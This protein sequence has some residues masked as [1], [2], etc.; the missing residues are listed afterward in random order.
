MTTPLF[1]RNGIASVL[2]I[3]SLIL[4]FICL[5]PSRCV[6]AALPAQNTSASDLSVQPFDIDDQGLYFLPDRLIQ[7]GSPG[8][9]VRYLLKYDQKRN[10]LVIEFPFGQL[11]KG[12]PSGYRV[13]EHSIDTIELSQHN[14]SLVDVARVTI[15]LTPG[16]KVPSE[17]TLTPLSN[18]RLLLPNLLHVTQSSAGHSSG[19]ITGTQTPAYTNSPI[20]PTPPPLQGGT[21]VSTTPALPTPPASSGASGEFKLGD[22][23]PIDVLEVEDQYF[24][25]RPRAG[26]GALKVKNQFYLESPHRFVLDI[27]PA[28]ISSKLFGAEANEEGN[29]PTFGITEW[30]GWGVR[31]SQN[32]P[33]TVRVVIETKESRNF[34]V[35]QGKDNAFK[36]SL[37]IEPREAGGGFWDRLRNN[38]KVK[39]PLSQLYISAEQTNAPTKFRL[40]SEQP[41]Q[42]KV[43]TENAYRFTVDLPNV[44]SPKEPLA[45]DV[46]RF[47]YLKSVT[48]VQAAEGSRLIVESKLPLRELRSTPYTSDNALELSFMVGPKPAPVQ[49]VATG[50]NRKDFTIVVDAGH[51]G[52]D[53]GAIR[54]GIREKDL[55]LN[56]ALKLRDEL[57]SRG[58]TVF[59][60]RSEDEF[61]S[62]KEIT[63]EAASY[64]PDIFIS[65][66]HNSSTNAAI[67][68]LETYYYHGFSL[69]LAKDIHANLAS[70]LP[71]V[72]R[73]VRQA[74][75]YVINHTSV[76]SVLLELGY[77]SNATEREAIA[78][79]W[80][81]KQEAKAIADGVDAYLKRVGR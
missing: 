67:Y 46:S 44:S 64:K 10:Q 27:E 7:G 28:M 40:E 49:P 11:K 51:G 54:E 48:H 70:S 73:G 43:T 36:D 81:Q 35:L 38:K 41:I 50:V 74:K 18:G 20:V 37:I 47:S 75:F 69:N 4:A 31:V 26:M 78:N 58:Y 23:V 33:T 56:V 62:L 24:L 12:L 19:V 1:F 42:Y 71:V 32:T 53:H 80:R 3:F 39:T 52:K 79:S 9:Q 6:A 29:F 68:G 8:Q 16:T 45:F 76:P 21:V 15:N 60:T 22:R 13:G 30:Q 55:N 77:V 2:A 72:D 57:Q 5:S 59:M 63:E 66:H 14:G 61:L 65:V 25:L 34:N 17:Y